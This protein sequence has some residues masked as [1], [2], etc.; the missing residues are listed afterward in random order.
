VL[1]QGQH[2]FG[3]RHTENL[4]LHRQKFHIVVFAI[5]GALE[6]GGESAARRQYE[7]F[8]YPPPNNGDDAI[9]TGSPSHLL[10]IDHFLFG[11]KRDWTRPF[12]ALIAGGGTGNA[13]IMLARQLRDINCPAELVYVDLST[14]SREIA[15]VRARE[16]GL[17]SITFYTG[18]FINI[19]SA[20]YG[21]FDYIDCCGVCTTFRTLPLRYG[22]SMRF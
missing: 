2:P 11:G 18:S 6:D 4:I 14:A 10:E 22:R 8:P 20:Q 1:F 7:V 16:Q 9:A 13:A 3:L 21:V 19:D 12:R 15:E 17:T 5:F